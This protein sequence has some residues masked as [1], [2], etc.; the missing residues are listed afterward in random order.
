MTFNTYLLF[1]TLNMPVEDVKSQII[2]IAVVTELLTARN[3]L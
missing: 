1:L 2:L 3:F